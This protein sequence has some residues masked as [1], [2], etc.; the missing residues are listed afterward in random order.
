MDLWDSAL[1]GPNLTQ[2]KEVLANAN[3]DILVFFHKN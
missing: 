1:W 2:V 3:Y